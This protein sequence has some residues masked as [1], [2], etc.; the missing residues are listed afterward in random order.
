MVQQPQ[1]QAVQ[2]PQPIQQQPVLPTQAQV[3]RPPLQ[4]QTPQQPVQP[5]PQPQALRPKPQLQNQQQQQQPQP[6]QNQALPSSPIL[7]NLLHGK[8]SELKANDQESVSLNPSSKAFMYKRP[9]IMWIPITYPRFRELSES[10]VKR[11][12][13]QALFDLYLLPR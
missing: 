7:T 10:K 12:L 3:Q 4:T 8:N 5:Q 6:V 1:P 2:Q 13:R 9:N 11:N